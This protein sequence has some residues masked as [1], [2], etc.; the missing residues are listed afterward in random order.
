[1]ASRSSAASPCAGRHVVSMKLL[2]SNMRRQWHVNQ[3]SAIRAA[4]S[5]STGHHSHHAEFEEYKVGWPYRNAGKYAD[6]KD[7]N[8]GTCARHKNSIE[9]K[10]YPKRIGHELCESIESILNS[11]RSIERERECRSTH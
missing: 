11:N 10:L 2:I 6:E 4:S 7:C 9:M 8:T 3:K 5:N 1:M